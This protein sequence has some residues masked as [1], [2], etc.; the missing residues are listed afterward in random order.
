MAQGDPSLT[1]GATDA[2]RKWRYLPAHSDSSHTAES[3]A[4]VKVQ[5]KLHPEQVSAESTSGLP[6]CF[7]TSAVSPLTTAADSLSAS[8][9][10]NVGGPVTAPRAVYSPAPT[11]DDEDR[12]AGVQGAV[13]LKITVS[14]DGEV[15]DLKWQRA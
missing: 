5:F 15:K 7:F 3:T 6:A 9:V 12:R 1:R 8:Q 10:Y 11:Y 4:N 2:V 13:A 14:R